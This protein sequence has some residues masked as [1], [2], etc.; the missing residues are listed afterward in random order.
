MAQVAADA[1]LTWQERSVDDE[2]GLRDRYGDLVP[3]VLVDGV[4]HAC[5][6][7]DPGRLA[8]AVEQGGARRRRR[9]R[10]WSRGTP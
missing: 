6:R 9:W 4:Q 8:A 2:P 3:V 7:V 1:G 10:V 5:W